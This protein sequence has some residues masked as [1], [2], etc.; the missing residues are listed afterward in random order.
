MVPHL[1]FYQ[2]TLI[3]LVWLC[4]MLQ[5]VWPS[6]CA[7]ASPTPPQPTPPQLR[8]HASCLRAAARARWTR[9]R[10]SAPIRTVSIGVGWGWAISVPMD[11]LPFVT[12]HLSIFHPICTPGSRRMRRAS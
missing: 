3:A 11:F 8:H 7:T 1:F 10:T 4:L 9:R 6:D 5:W 2:L 12:P